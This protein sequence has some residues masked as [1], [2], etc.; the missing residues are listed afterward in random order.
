MKLENVKFVET[1]ILDTPLHKLPRVSEELKIEL[2]IKRDDLTG[3]G[4]GGN[5]LRKLDY[6]V[7]D[8][9]VTGCNVL[10][11][12]GGYQ[13]NHG[14]LTAA[15][16]ARLGLKCVMILDGPP[17]KEA[18]GNLILDKM[19]GA[20]VVFM[21]DSSFAGAADYAE[22]YAALKA[23]A[24]AVVIAK[25]EAM[26]DKV[27]SIPV[28]GSSET[29]AAGYI[30]CAK[31]LGEQLKDMDV[32]PD[33]I[34]CAYGSAGTYAGMTV[35]LKYYGVPG[36][37]VGVCVS[38]KDD[39]AIK[40]GL[41]YI[42]RTAAT[43]E[44]G[45][46]FDLADLWIERG[47]V[48]VG[49]NQPDPDTRAASYFMASREAILLDFCY[50]GKVFRGLVDMVKSGK[51]AE[52]SK[53]VMLHTGGAPGLFSDRHQAACQAELWGDAPEVFTL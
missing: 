40:G 48:G 42:N 53:V 32:A 9:I 18:T 23:K 10:L 12:Y 13:T 16:A 25:Y 22:K 43:W 24:T 46:T 2:Y 8:A 21:D 50:T 52:G 1:G 35:G 7:S 14:R 39:A 27:Y 28:G 30:K 17:P 29:G 5:K 34:F 33:Y 31:E 45:L 47:Y 4:L 37:L 41:D 20:E 3:F 26:G 51:I 36:S 49:Y 6:L 44:T 38:H 19:M 11:T 15:A